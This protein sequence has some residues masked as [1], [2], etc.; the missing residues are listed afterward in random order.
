MEAGASV[1][2]G[3][4]PFRP[5]VFASYGNGWRQLWKYFLPLFLI[6]LI[7]FAI[8]AAVSVPQYI[9]QFSGLDNDV[10]VGVFIIF[11]GFVSFAFG[12]FISGPLGY[13]LYYAYLRAARGDTVDIKDMF[14]GFKK[15]WSA[16]GASLLVEIIVGVGFILL[17][18]PGIYLA[19][20]LAFVPYLVVDKKM[21][22]GKAFGESWRMAS[23]GRAW[24]VFLLGLLA[25]P[26]FIA[27]LIVLLVGA[28]V[29]F[30]WISTALASLYH[31]I[32]S[33]QATA[34][35]APMGPVTL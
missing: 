22:V 14:A 25:I 33:E 8:T 4:K 21:G 23:H 29:S 30:M 27:G 20:K 10:A 5:G 3:V 7:Y 16:V 19:C 18:V 34:V 11:W 15:Y 28:I 6:G 24:K 26:I 13:G 1:T 31:A 17:I 9:V 12:I 32:D 35:T 2:M